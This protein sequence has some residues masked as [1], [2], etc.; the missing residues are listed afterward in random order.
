[1]SR[2][3]K[4]GRPAVSTPALLPELPQQ[5]ESIPQGHFGMPAVSSI[6]ITPPIGSAFYNAHDASSDNVVVR[7][8]DVDWRAAYGEARMAIEIAKESSDM[9][10]PLKAVASAMSTLMKS[11]DVGFF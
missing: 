1:M 2:L 8:R 3:R 6:A 11:C 7:G 5:L 9:S 10:L 4:S